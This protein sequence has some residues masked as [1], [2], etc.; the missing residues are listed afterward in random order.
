MS[1]QTIDGAREWVTHYRN[2]GSITLPPKQAIDALEFVLNNLDASE[3]HNSLL[4]KALNKWKAYF[5][6]DIP[7]T[8]DE[9]EQ[10][11][12]A[13]TD[14][15]F[16]MEQA[17]GTDGGKEL[18]GLRTKL[19]AAEAEL[20]DLRRYKTNKETVDESHKV[21]GTDTL[22]ECNCVIST[23]TQPVF[24]ETFHLESCPARKQYEACLNWAKVCNDG[25]AKMDDKRK[26]AESEL[27]WRW[28]VG[29]QI[30]RKNGGILDFDLWKDRETRE[31]ERQKASGV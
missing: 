25:L 10:S 31:Y 14:A 1:E 7:K 24:R 28:Q 21:L 23:P 2:S 26:K 19:A 29:F 12:Q 20:A 11:G 17:L 30:Y 8:R 13:F 9:H 3:L 16:E 6:S 5:Q 15:W 22:R 27:K 4:R 18:S